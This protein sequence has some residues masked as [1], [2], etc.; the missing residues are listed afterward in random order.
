MY[1]VKH[2]PNN[3]LTS[4]Q[5]AELEHKHG[6]LQR[7]RAGR[8]KGLPK[9]QKFDSE[10]P[11]LKWGDKQYVF[12]GLISIP[13]LPSI[14]SEQF[15]GKRAEFRGKRTLV[16][17][18]PVYSTGT[19]ALNVLVKYTDAAKPLKK[20]AALLKDTGTY[21]LM[22]VTDDEGNVIKQSGMLQYVEPDG[23]IHHQLNNCATVTTRLS[24]SKP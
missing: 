23:L 16:D 21:Y 1:L 3:P 19:D 12:P 7:Y 13:E 11:L 8:N 22:Q 20:L 18:T 5:I 4:E 9:I 2:D 14:V 6:A 15:L 10:Q 24:G 17:G